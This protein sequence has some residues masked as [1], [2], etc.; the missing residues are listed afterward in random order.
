MYTLKWMMFVLLTF[1]VKTGLISATVVSS[2]TWAGMY[3]ISYI[4]H[5]APLTAEYFQYLQNIFCA[6]TNFQLPY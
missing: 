4:L 3:K 1:Q 2:W 6:F 5:A